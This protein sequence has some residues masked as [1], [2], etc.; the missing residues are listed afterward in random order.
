MPISYNDQEKL[1]TLQTRNTTYQMKVDEYGV[2]LHTYYGAKIQEQD[3]SCLIVKSDKGFSGNPNDLGMCRAYSLDTL[4]QE[5]SCYGN[6]DYRTSAIKIQHKNG[7]HAL[8]LRYVSH[9]ILDL[10]YSIPQLP[11]M[12]ETKENKGETLKV[13]LKDTAT[14]IYVTIYYGI[15]ESLDIITRSVEV[16]NKGEESIYLKKVMSTCLDMK[17]YE[18]DVI[19]LYGKH[20]M[21]REYSRNK[22]HHGKQVVGSNRGHSSHHYNPFI[23]L[24]GE[25]TSETIGDCYGMSLV[26]SGDFV[27]EVEKDQTNQVRITMGIGTENFEYK[28]DKDECFNSPEVVMTFSENGIGQLSRNYHQAYRENLCRGKYKLERRPIL[29]NNWEGTYFDFDGQRLIDIAKEAA[30]LGVELFVMDDGW[31]GKRDNDVSG[32]G[33]WTVNEEKL[34][35][36]LNELAESI[37]ETGMKFGIWFEPECVSEDSD[38]YRDHPDWV[39]TVPGRN[40]VRS[41]HQLV[42]DFSKPE[43]CDNIYEQLCNVLDSAPI[44]YVKWDFN[45]SINDIFNGNLPA[46]RQGEV[47]HRYILG[48][49]DMLEKLVTRYPDI[50][51]ESCSGGGGRFDPGILYYTPQVWTSDNTDAI[52]R[53]KIQYGTSLCY[54]V[55]TMGSHVSM[56]PNH[57]TKRI[58]PLHTRGVVAMSGTFGYELDVQNMS[59]TEKEEIKDQIKVFKEHYEMIQIGDYYRITN[60]YDD[61]AYAVWQFVSKDKNEALVNIV[62]TH[63]YGNPSPVYVRLQGLN[64]DKIY[65]IKGDYMENKD[66]CISGQALMKAGIPL[67]RPR[68]EYDSFQLNLKVK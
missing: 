44:S 39:F 25:N 20:E 59:E 38:L 27:A 43:V 16:V 15:F 4:P 21:E 42:L 40:P 56:C 14:N 7:A 5:Y 23:I 55:S 18:Y 29:I 10:K 61:E 9:E 54:P 8:D 24:A 37:I 63:S 53:L 30:N 45:R 35:C 28:L 66:L 57:Q 1:I 65:C 48:L 34:G 51:F 49:Y 26:Y 46:D 52:E 60:P 33:D 36:S 41:R 17:S 50:L 64:P 6:G 19:T 68:V 58:T 62:S 31:F 3:L 47:A 2:V 22:V 13:K 32:L 12:Y 67:P 11:A